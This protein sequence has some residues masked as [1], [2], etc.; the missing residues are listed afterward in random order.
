MTTNTRNHLWTIRL[1]QRP[2]V[3]MAS[4]SGLIGHSHRD[5]CLLDTI[6]T[7]CAP[8]YSEEPLRFFQTIDMT[9]RMSMEPYDMLA[10]YWPWTGRQ[11]A[12]L[13]AS[14]ELQYMPRNEAWV[15]ENAQVS[16]QHLNCHIYNVVDRVLAE[17]FPGYKYHQ[18]VVDPTKE[19]IA[20]QERNR[21]LAEESHAYYHHRPL[22]A[23]ETKKAEEAELKNFK[24]Y[25]SDY[26]QQM[27]NLEHRV[28]QLQVTNEY[29]SAKPSV[30]RMDRAIVLP[31]EAGSAPSDT[32]TAESGAPLQETTKVRVVACGVVKKV[33]IV[34]DAIPGFKQGFHKP[35]ETPGH[36]WHVLDPM[37]TGEGTRFGLSASNLLQQMQVNCQTAETQFSLVEDGTAAVFVKFDDVPEERRSG[38]ECEVA[39]VEF[40]KQKTNEVFCTYI[41]FYREA[42]LKAIAN[43]W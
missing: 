20:R 40:S 13:F 14:D 11:L 4:G 10:K 24:K 19:L 32:T 28:H 3:S 17:A 39:S 25:A 15:G 7:P 23:S 18:H 42:I 27:K 31:K 26:L 36:R 8:R 21:L 34:A 37:L 1:L 6:D 38:S 12:E 2:S 35:P 9:T 16:A 33:G 43:A 30:S 22:T 5:A 41:G 29:L